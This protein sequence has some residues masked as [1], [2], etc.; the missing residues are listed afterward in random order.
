MIGRTAEASLVCPQPALSRRHACVA[1]AD[2]AWWVE[3]LDSANGTTV[4]GVAVTR[5][6]L[7]PGAVVGFGGAVRYRFMPGVEVPTAGLSMVNRLL[8]LKLTPLGGGRSHVLRRRLTVV[9]RNATADLRLDSGQVSGI[10]ARILRRGGCVLL[11]DTGSRNGTTVNGDTVSQAALAPGDLVSFGDVVFR[12]GRSP[13]P[14]GGAMVGGASGV[15][16]VAAVAV[17]AA[18]LT[19]GEAEPL[20]TRQMYLDQ[21]STSLV[22]AIRA[23]DRTPPARE[24]AL[25]QIDIARRSLIAADLMRPDR[26]TP[27]EVLA[28]MTRAA[29]AP[30]VA[31]ALRGRG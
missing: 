18:L 19:G 30:E 6:V 22:A 7:A 1:Y 10:H 26:Q 13:V 31:R 11:R 16:A 5:A 8:C 3:D 20:W 15:L 12:V 23:Q 17:V 27:D 9:G 29:G 21:V 14:T 4:D 24:V 2:G 25:A 28:A